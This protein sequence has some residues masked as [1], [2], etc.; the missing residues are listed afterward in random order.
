MKLTDQ[1]KK[2]LY[3]VIKEKKINTINSLSILTVL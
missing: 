3:L 2:C 1:Q